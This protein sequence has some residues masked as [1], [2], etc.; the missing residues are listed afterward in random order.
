MIFLGLQLKSLS[1]ENTVKMDDYGEILTV[2][3][4]YI[5]IGN[6]YYKVISN[7]YQN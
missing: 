6:Q 2:I 4:I 3:R 1:P 7:G 5:G